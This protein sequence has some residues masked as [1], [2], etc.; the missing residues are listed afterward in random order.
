M[1]IL[2]HILLP[3]LKPNSDTASPQP[4]SFLPKCSIT[5]NFPSTSLTVTN[6]PVVRADVEMNMGLSKRKH[7]QHGLLFD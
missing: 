7:A 6:V 1:L 5:L 2:I 4:S 3:A